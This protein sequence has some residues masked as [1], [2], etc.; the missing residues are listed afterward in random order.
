MAF[1]MLPYRMVYLVCSVIPA[2]LLVLA[3]DLKFLCM[4]MKEKVKEI[5]NV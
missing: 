5:E 2:T 4:I 3:T 1:D